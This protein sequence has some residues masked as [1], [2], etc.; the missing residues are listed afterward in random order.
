MYSSE[1][2]ILF[3]WVPRFILKHDVR[4]FLK[5]VEIKKAFSLQIK[6]LYGEGG[7]RNIFPSKKDA[8]S[9]IYLLLRKRYIVNINKLQKICQSIDGIAVFKY[10]SVLIFYTRSS[11]KVSMI[12]KINCTH[13]EKKY[14]AFN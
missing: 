5:I 4:I 11:K 6:Y 2:N 13:W 12:L 1:S 3:S 10:D 7:I 8:E 9:S 14:A